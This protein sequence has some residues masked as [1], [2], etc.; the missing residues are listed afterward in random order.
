[1]GL[2]CSLRI[3]DSLFSS[4]FCNAVLGRP[5]TRWTRCSHGV[6]RDLNSWF[7]PTK[8]L[9][10]LHL[11]PQ[12]WKNTQSVQLLIPSANLYI[13]Y[14]SDQILGSRT[15]TPKRGRKPYPCASVNLPASKGDLWRSKCESVNNMPSAVG[16]QKR[17]CEMGLDA[18]SASRG[19]ADEASKWKGARVL[20]SGGVWKALVPSERGSLEM[21]RVRRKM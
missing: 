12:P 15:Q 17:S 8:L 5:I 13:R 11:R 7:H 21:P 18:N 9:F 6:L 19:Q 16:M 1:M 4:V 20:Q 10:E 14:P 2:S 3:G